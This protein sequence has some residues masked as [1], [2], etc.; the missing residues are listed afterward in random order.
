MDTSSTPLPPPSHHHEFHTVQETKP[1]AVVTTTP[2]ETS[3]NSSSSNNSNSNKQQQQ[4]RKCKGKGG[5]DNNK[6]RYRGVRQRSWGKWVAEIREPRKRTRKWLG[7]FSTAEDAARAY[8]RA[9]LILYG[10]RA[11]LNLQP[12]SSSSH[13]SSH[14]S[15]SSSSSSS[16]N[17]SSSSNT[18]RPLLPRP[19]SFSFSN[20]SHLPLLFNSSS[21]AFLPYAA[22]SF[23]T[24]H[25]PFI[26]NS[27]TNLLQHSDKLVQLQQHRDQDQDQDKESEH[28]CGSIRTTTSYQNRSV[29]QEQ[30][31][32]GYYDV[33]NNQEEVIQNQNCKVEGGNVSSNQSNIDGTVDLDQMGGGNIGS[34]SMWPLTSEEDYTTTLWDYNDPFFFDF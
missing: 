7:T 33:C 9:A 24:F 15:S 12:S 4:H 16:R 14:N 19:S 2:S 21:N 17:S 32:A 13:S 10:S 28:A 1:T 20:S 3:N 30:Q 25:Q 31:H 8:D 27:N 26:Q 6:F 29:E 5:P 11:Q 34:P 22:Y 18:L 23:N